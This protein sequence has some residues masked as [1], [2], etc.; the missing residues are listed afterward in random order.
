M[1]KEELDKA[2]Q[3]AYEKASATTVA[4]PQ[5]IQLLLYAYYKQGNHKRKLIP[6]ENIK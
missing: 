1:T 5:D 6:L 3:A 2:F 4:L